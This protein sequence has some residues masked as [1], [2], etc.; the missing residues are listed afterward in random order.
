MHTDFFAIGDIVTEPFIKLKDAEAHCDIDSAACTIC[1][2]FGDKIPY[3]SA[4]LL[5]AVGNAAN[6]AVAAARLGLS[7][8]LR[9]YVGDDRYGPECLEVLKAE[10]VSTEYMVTEPGKQTNYHYV[11]WFG[12]ERTILVKH[13]EFSYEVPELTAAPKWL[14]LSSLAANSLPYHQGIIE[15]LAK[16]P[17]IK[18]A[19][20][21]GT[22]QMKLG[23]AALRPLYGRSDVFFC[24]KEEAARILELPDL[25]DIK[26]LLTSVH[27][28]GP[29]IV[30]IT[31]GTNGAYAYDGERLLRIP[32]YPDARAPFERTGAGDAFASTVT[33]ALALGRPLDEALLWGPINSMSV[34]QEVGAQKGLLTREMLESYL[35]K[36]PDD[37]R[38]T[39][40]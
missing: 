39:E 27:A 5:P 40:L 2:R 28:L 20:Q 6:A 35:A 4:T 3:E 34:V 30:C 37:Y 11:L 9:A 14:Y 24:N 17:E 10:G 36:A 1:M 33:S 29:K 16:M 21:P 7:S 32:M 31:D 38:V 22:F 26:A 19:F 23:V 12:S 8:A 13:E 18:L 15:L 25:T